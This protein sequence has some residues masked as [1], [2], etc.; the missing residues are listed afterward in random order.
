MYVL[1]SPEFY[2]EIT[3]VMVSLDACIAHEDGV[4]GFLL[5]KN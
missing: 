5:F 1:L 2:T 4:Y 3:I